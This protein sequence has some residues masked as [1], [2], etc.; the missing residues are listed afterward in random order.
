[1]AGRAVIMPCAQGGGYFGTETVMS[2]TTTRDEVS[3]DVGAGVKLVQSVLG[4]PAACIA[5]DAGR[6]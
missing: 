2:E 5:G 6:D 1:M 4:K 3:G